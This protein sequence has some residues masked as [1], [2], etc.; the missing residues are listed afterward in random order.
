MIKSFY[1]GLWNVTKDKDVIY[2]GA[3]FKEALS[4]ISAL[5]LLSEVTK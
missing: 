2:Q 4:V 5:M 3:S 1:N